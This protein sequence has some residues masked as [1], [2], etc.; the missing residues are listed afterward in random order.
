MDAYIAQLL[1]R[2]DVGRLQERDWARLARRGDQHARS[3]LI[4][5]GLRSVALRALLLGF[6]GD[7]L[8]DAV[9]DGTIALIES[10]DK[11]DPERGVRLATFS[12]WPVA[13]AMRRNNAH[14]PPTELS[15]VEESVDNDDPFS[16]WLDGLRPELVAVMRCRFGS[17]QGSA[18]PR[19]EVA[20]QL[21]LTQ[22]QVRVREAEALRALTD[23]LARVGTR[24]S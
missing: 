12:W 1:R 17:S 18:R 11:F 23:D 4:D 13:R 21:G 10:V 8:R 5:S 9:Q 7:E 20:Q 22:N 14:A 2:S 24:A 19:R 16:W 6:R 15:M 3:Q